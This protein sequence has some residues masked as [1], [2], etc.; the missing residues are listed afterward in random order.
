MEL[1]GLLWDLQY[2]VIVLHMEVRSENETTKTMK[3]K[4]IFRL[5]RHID[6]GVDYYRLIK[7]IQKVVA[8]SYVMNG[9]SLIVLKN[10]KTKTIMQ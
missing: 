3:A 8:A 5:H 7:E 4:E 6:C 2:M 10:G 9:N 1:I